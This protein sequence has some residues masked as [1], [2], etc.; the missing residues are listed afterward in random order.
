MQAS[1]RR[2][3]YYE[4]SQSR[5]AIAYHKNRNS[6]SGPCAITRPIARKRC[7]TSVNTQEEP[8][9]RSRHHAMTD[10]HNAIQ[11]ATSKTVSRTHKCKYVPHHPTTP[12]HL[13]TDM[14]LVGRRSDSFYGAGNGRLF[15][16]MEKPSASRLSG[17]TIIL[18]TCS[19][20]TD[21]REEE[22]GTERRRVL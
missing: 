17:A 10:K 18:V 5:I 16:D 11:K 7:D 1:L 21:D 19:I 12:I 9:I 8:Q 4:K 2:F 22:G 15:I 6:Q 3:F 14:Q 20:P 13:F